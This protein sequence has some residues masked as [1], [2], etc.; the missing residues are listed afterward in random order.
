M[1][2]IPS[3]GRALAAA[4]GL[5]LASA[6]LLASPAAHAAGITAVQLL[7]GSH[8]SQ[9]ST[10]T[11]KVLGSGTCTVFIE[12]N[13][14]SDVE[15][16]FGDYQLGPAA[17][18]VS[19]SFQANTLGTFQIAATGADADGELC[20]HSGAFAVNTLLHV[21]HPALLRRPDVL[22]PIPKRIPAPDP[23]PLA[24]RP[25]VEVQRDVDTQRPTLERT[26]RAR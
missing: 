9:G 12:T 26:L 1:W 22:H 16:G 10:V 25:G 19:L 18:P 6:L 24:T 2:K 7:P 8:V 5:W 21:Q 23:G 11:V 13:G 15:G 14:A 4:S 3:I 20:V 17:L